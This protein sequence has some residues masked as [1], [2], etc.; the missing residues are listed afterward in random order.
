M[1]STIFFRSCLSLLI[2]LP[3]ARVSAQP[4]STISYPKAQKVNQVDTYHGTAVEDPYR[5][6]E[7]DNSIETKDWVLQQNKLT[8]SFL[9]TIPFR[10][11]L[12]SRM[13]NHW[14]FVRFS[15]PFRCGSSYFYFRQD[16]N[17]NQ[18]VLF[19]MKSLEYVPFSYFDPNRLSEK[20]TTSLAQTVPSPD[21]LHLA[22]QVSEAGSDWNTIRIK[23]VK[24]MKSLPE[25]LTGVKF[26]NIAWFK[27]GFYY[28]RYAD[29]G[30]GSKANEY[31][32]IYYHKLGSQQSADSLIWE[33]REHPRRN[34]SASVTHDQR[35]LV[36]SGSESTSGNNLFIQDLTRSGSKPVAVVK[37]F[38]H[39]FDLVGTIGKDLLFLTNFKAG[40]N[41]LVL[42]NPSDISPD[43]WKDFI[44][45]QEE[46][47]RSATICW[48]NVVLH[49]MQDASSRL[50]VYNMQGVKTHQIPLDGLGTVD[51]ISGSPEDTVMFYSFSTFTMPSTVYRYHL[52]TA[53]MG[54]QF[55]APL[56]Y[57]P[58]RF[59]TKQVFYTSKDGTRIPMFIVHKK[60]IELKGDNPTL[61]FGYGG[62]NISK[63]PEF[64][65]ERIVFLEQ[66]GLFAMPS[67]RGGGE[68]GE[69][70][71]KAGT[72]LS[73]QNV[74]DD[75]IAAA[76][77]L[78]KEGF[79]APSKLAIG[80]RSNGGLLVGA[81]MTQ[82]PDLFRVALPAVGV[83]DM[84]RFQKFTIGWAWTGDYGSSDNPE[85]FKALLAYSPLHNLK[86]G[87]SY[88]ATLVTT[89]D[90]DD[91]VVPGHSF[92]FTARLQEMQSG[93]L[94]VLIRVDTDAGHGAGKPLSKSLDEQSDI[95]T[96]LFHHLGMSL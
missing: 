5:W 19:Y 33:D 1:L 12:K 47:I 51:G 76:E 17:Q 64:K 94:P 90:H 28:S 29:A 79:T 36:I 31:H 55:K 88:P 92:K 83:M 20:G 96:F 68:Y 75:F 65:A 42:I 44:P 8:E 4:G 2:V 61:L 78:I 70:W 84:L 10:D 86:P 22:F 71:H 27:D 66:G 89:A 80:G 59:E 21:G 24:S 39:D 38:D 45:E 32:R 40:R 34:F 87:T 14:N 50:N 16:V 26:S 54:I 82:R 57:D 37:S 25:V 18:P 9:Q 13:K 73:K 58:A 77:Y 93:T 49:T 53:R 81:C 30:S 67:L 60:G 52:N 69:P 48:K 74:F 56:P 43:K 3:V 95:F 15:A 72:K 35:Y 11:S 23:E 91:R 6:L 7:D 41:K 46:I 85:E 62:F 63:T